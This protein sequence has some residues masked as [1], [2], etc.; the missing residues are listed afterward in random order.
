[1][2]RGKLF[3]A[4]LLVFA[5]FILN[6]AMVSAADYYVNATT[7]ND[8]NAGTSPASAWK[9]ISKLNAA[10]FLPGD[11]IYFERGEVWREQLTVPSS[12]SSGNPITFGAYGTGEKPLINGADLV[13]GF[14]QVGSELESDGNT[15]A[16]WNFEND[17]TDSSGNDKT[18]S[19]GGG[20]ASY[21]T[22]GAPFDSYIDL[23]GSD[24]LTRADDEDFDFDANESFTIEGWIRSTNNGSVQE[25]IR[26]CKYS[27][28]G[29]EGCFRLYID[30]DGHLN[31][32]IHDGDEGTGSKYLY[33]TTNIC[34]GNWHHFALRYDGASEVDSKTTLFIDGSPE[35]SP[36]GVFSSGS[37][38][39]SI[40]LAVGATETGSQ[41]L[42]AQIEQIRISNVAHTNFPASITGNVWQATVTTEP[43]LL[44]LDEGFGTHKASVGALSSTG[45]WYWSGNTLSLYSATDPDAAYTAIEAGARDYCISD[46]GSAKNYLSFENIGLRGWN[47]IGASFLANS[48]TGLSFDS[49]EAKFGGPYEKTGTVAAAIYD[50]Y[51]SSSY[52]DVTIDEIYGVGLYCQTKNDHTITRLTLGMCYQGV[53]YPNDA[54]I[55]QSLSNVTITGMD[56]DRE[57]IP[58]NANTKGHI[59]ITDASDVTITKSSFVGGSWGIGITGTSTNVTI[60]KSFFRDFGNG[61]DFSSPIQAYNTDFSN[62]IIRNNL[63]T[64]FTESAI[65]VQHESNVPTGVRIYNNAIYNNQAINRFGIA[66]YGFVGDVKNNIIYLTQGVSYMH[67]YIGGDNIDSDYNQFGPER[68]DFLRYGGTTYSTLADYRA[69]SSSETN[70]LSSDPLFTDP[71][72]ND[73]TLQVDSPAIDAGENLGASYDDALN[74]NSTWPNS[75]LTL[76]Q[77]DYGTG[78]EIGAYV[79]GDTI[80]PVISFSCSPTSVRIG[81]AVV[82]SCSA[83]D[84]TDPNPDVSYTVNPSTS[85]IGTFITTCTATDNS[86]NSASSNIS[87]VVSSTGD[88][89]G[90]GGGETSATP[91]ITE[92]Q[93]VEEI[94]PQE[95]IIFTG[96]NPKTGIVLTQKQE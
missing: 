53:G 7:G 25:V 47:W 78:W 79:Y 24:Y 19:V 5:L 96:F 2:K 39:S 91:S 83:T 23:S 65:S 60:E 51:S 11:N 30:P 9:T 38:G 95:S 50:K 59:L 15:I 16:L 6:S 85:S 72:N 43:L 17:L 57:G 58:I 74:P 90:G 44:L 18:L 77:D 32:I 13:T 71:N 45:D 20:V 46:G 34:D 22:T 33:G 68:A 89:N 35:G 88:G 81:Q 1:M 36:V 86:G 8:G 31:P 37:L 26:K 48:G 40:G 42:T 49:V 61:Q 27:I 93:T 73:F 10:S 87:Y 29:S 70:S 82:C 54:M 63:I 92:N 66:V 41:K 21:D 4:L 62:L 55:L 52:T 75:V 12:G 67:S 76:D 28:D 80:T 69:A 64:D 14:S 84:N 3:L 56:S 94:T